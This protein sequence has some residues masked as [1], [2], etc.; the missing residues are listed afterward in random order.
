[1]RESDFKTALV[2]IQSTA[3]TEAGAMSLVARGRADLRVREEA[4]E[5]LRKGLEFHHQQQYEDAF[6]CFERGI[7]LD[8]NHPD[9]QYMLGALYC[10]GEGVLQDDAQAAAWYRKAALQGDG[11]AQYSLGVLYHIGEGV[12]QDDAEA[13]IWYRRAADQGNRYAQ[14]SLGVLYHNGEGVP[15][16]DAE[17][18]VW[19]RKAAEQGHA[20]AQER[21]GSMYYFGRGVSREYAQ[22]E[23]WYRKAADQGHAPAQFYLGVLYDLG[24]GV[25]QDYVQMA[26]WNRRAAEQGHA[27]AQYELGI[28]YHNG[29]GVPQD[30]A[31]AEAWYSKSAENG[32]EPAKAALATLRMLHMPESSNPEPTSVSEW[33][34]P[35]LTREQNESVVDDLNAIME[36]RFF[37]LS[38]VKSQQLPRILLVEDEQSVRD[39]VVPILLSAGFDCRESATGQSA[40][41]L[42][43]SGVRFNLILSNLL[44][45]EVDGLTLLLHVKQN[46][47][48]IP[49]VFVTAISDAAVR[50]EA[51]RNGADGFLQKP[52]EGDQLLAIVCSVLAKA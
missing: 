10:F 30:Y 44:L 25:A 36:Q 32:Y 35:E 1:M 50:E 23:A 15:Q 4:E 27:E 28:M 47:P 26:V 17:A 18:A 33:K 14:N 38:S 16:D 9:L 8:P 37:S 2:P 24:Q 49:F 11:D 34:C 20:G 6:R 40:I 13:A 52:V 39:I 12:P 3:L 51:M 29:H 31:Q 21:L 19:I 42:L 46:Y 22:A 41:D 45:P 43:R 48:R 5:W 7:E